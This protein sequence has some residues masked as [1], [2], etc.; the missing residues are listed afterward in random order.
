MP[1]VSDEAAQV[2]A[3][4]TESERLRRENETLS[5]VVGL[6]GSSPDLGHVLDRVVD[7]LTQVSGCHACFV[8][9]VAGDRLQLR[10]ASPVYG[11]HVGRIEFGVDEG[12]AGWSVRHRQ[13]AVIQDRAMDDPRTNFVPEL[14]EERFQS[15]AA[16]PVPS[17][18]GEILGVIVLHT[19]APHEFDESTLNVL[20]QTASL[21]AGTIENAKLYDEARGRVDALTRLSRLS[22]RIAGVTQRADLYRAATTGIREM[23][24]CD[25]CRLLELDPGGRLVIV[26]ADPEHGA[27]IGA[28]DGT[29]EVLLEMLQSSPSETLRLRTVVGRVLG[30]DHPP[31]AA[32]A[33]PVAAGSELL[34]ALVVGAHEPW[35]EHAEDLLRAVAHQIAV[36][37][38]K[39]ELIESLSEENTARELFGAL[40][41]ER[42]EVAEARA[43]TLGR[44]LRAP[45]VL[46]DAR[47]FGSPT[48][49]LGEEARLERALRQAKPGTVC[50]TDGR[51]VR[52]LIPARGAGVEAAR[53]LAAG[54]DAIGREHGVVLG[55]STARRGPGG[56][57]TAL[58][59][60]R[61]AATVALA[62]L[63]GGGALL[64]GDMG[65][66]RYLVGLVETGGPDDE[67]RAA[68]QRLV[69]YDAARQ[70][71]LLTTLELF[72]THGRSS[73]TTSRALTVHVNTLRQRLER[74]EALTGLDLDS[75]DLLA[76]QLAIKVARLRKPGFI[77]DAA[78][79]GQGRDTHH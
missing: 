1:V 13:A 60:A 47:P 3:A 26:A 77:Q 56:S 27:I 8:Y 62:L 66:Y 39:S 29:A 71:Q 34:G 43:H 59:E 74:I 18:S 16:V 79:R 31:E 45:H 12:L 75:Q 57:R 4:A 61:D 65:A 37:L 58:G 73:T 32:L 9:L 33:V 52:A 7:L 78:P 35:R 67:L 17:R 51:R 36:A 24:P 5:A 19:A 44:D 53:A 48:F 6:V 20:P 23:L 50:D 68:V 15:I 55:V 76:L 49:R 38:K 11:R 28:Y 46:L 54:L 70:T 22:E 40:E 2:D 10:A 42:W 63:G 64:Y 69:E 14:E 72:L 41:G 25:D 21:I 30:R